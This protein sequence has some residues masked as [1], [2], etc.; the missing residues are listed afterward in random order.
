MIPKKTKIVTVV[1]VMALGLI[2]ILG[3]SAFVIAPIL[4]YPVT[5]DL[6][7]RVT[8]VPPET[9]ESQPLIDLR[10]DSSN[11]LFW[12]SSPV[13]VSDLQQRMEDAVQKD[14]T[15]QPEL[16]I[17]ADAGSDYQVMAE[18][19]ASARNSNVKKIV[20]SQ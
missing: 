3:A 8:S 15:N 17:D 20:F 14:P 18:I 11:Q 6:P 4:T 10:V 16:R 1:L 12:N 13:A 9:Q 2:G 5:V 19:L 7:Q